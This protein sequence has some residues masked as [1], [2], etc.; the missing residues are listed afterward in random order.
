MKTFALSNEEA[1]KS[2]FTHKAIITY[3]DLVAKGAVLTALF[4]LQAYVAGVMFGGGAYKLVTTFDGG[5]TATLKLDVGWDGATT[6]DP[7]GLI[8]NYELHEDGTEI[9]YGD[10]N[11]AVFATLR[12]GYCALDAGTLQALFT[13]TSANMDVLTQ[14][15]VHIYWRQVDLNLI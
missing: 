7:D 6:D 3:L 13:V 5:A 2:G 4:D 10:A 14:G 1:A 9:K 11:G 15:E 8:D 12:T